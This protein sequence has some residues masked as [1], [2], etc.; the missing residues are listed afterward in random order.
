MFVYVAQTVTA[1]STEQPAEIEGT[2]GK[3]REEEEEEEK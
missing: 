3:R 2:G 1:E